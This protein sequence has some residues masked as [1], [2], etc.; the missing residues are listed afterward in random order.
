MRITACNT[1]RI[2]KHRKVEAVPTVIQSSLAVN[3]LQTAIL[4]LVLYMS[5]KREFRNE[6][7]HELI[8]YGTIQTVLSMSML[9][10]S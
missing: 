3:R 1:F 8:L 4:Q 9:S 7:A 5:R 2:I 10:L 6:R